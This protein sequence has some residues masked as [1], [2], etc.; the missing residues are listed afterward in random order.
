MSPA[1]TGR[2]LS[3]WCATS[4]S[5]GGTQGGT[6]PPREVF[7]LYW[8]P[9]RISWQ[10]TNTTRAWRAGGTTAR[11]RAGCGPSSS[12]GALCR[13]RGGATAGA[14]ANGNTV[15]SVCW[16]RRN[17]TWLQLLAGNQNKMKAG[18]P[19]RDRTGDLLNAIQARSQLRYRPTRRES[20]PPIVTG[21]WPQ[22]KADGRRGRQ[23]GRVA[24]DA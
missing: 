23:D 9:S 12:A 1:S 15:P 13:P 20:Q 4:A 16:N 22:R 19:D 17:R 2:P 8:C 3:D 14:V 24:A 5:R 7:P 11:R 21:R 10:L 6:L 18:G